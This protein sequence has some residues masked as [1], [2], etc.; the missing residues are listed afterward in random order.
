MYMS[1]N[2]LRGYVN[3]NKNENEMLNKVIRSKYP[4]PNSR[5]K[6]Q[7]LGNMARTIKNRGYTAISGITKKS[8]I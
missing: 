3:E 1:K 4:P 5:S 6:I 8:M 2:P 7:K